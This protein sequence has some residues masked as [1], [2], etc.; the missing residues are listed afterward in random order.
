MKW[1][2]KGLCRALAWHDENGEVFTIV[3]QSFS[4]VLVNAL[5][6]W[7]WA[8]ICTHT[9]LVRRNAMRA[10]SW[11][12]YEDNDWSFG[13]VVA[14]AYWLALAIALAHESK[15]MSEYLRLLI[16]S[17]TH[18]NRCH[19]VLSRDKEGTERAK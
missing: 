3:R 16:P 18:P 5:L 15:G 10:L 7:S 19:R 8:A 11:D 14:V 9:L 2:A 13:Q 17:V 1:A 4:L 12:D 6:H